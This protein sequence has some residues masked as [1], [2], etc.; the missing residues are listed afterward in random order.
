MKN[1]QNR[2]IILDLLKS[3][4]TLKQ[5]IAADAVIIFKLFNDAINK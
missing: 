2:K 4:A 3:K 1:E 5:N